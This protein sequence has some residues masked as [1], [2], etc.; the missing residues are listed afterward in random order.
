MID[1][2]LSFFRVCVCVF[3]CRCYLSFYFWFLIV[4]FFL[5]FFCL[6]KVTNSTKTFCI[7]HVCKKKR[8]KLKITQP[9]IHFPFF[10][11]RSSSLTCARELKIYFL[12]GVKKKFPESSRR[13]LAGTGIRDQNSTKICALREGVLNPINARYKLKGMNRA[14]RYWHASATQQRQH[15]PLFPMTPPESASSVSRK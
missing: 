15:T 2:D 12:K 10:I 9:T 4:A 5:F 14:G 3:F 7:K 1:L 13:N 8:Q 11:V 6:W